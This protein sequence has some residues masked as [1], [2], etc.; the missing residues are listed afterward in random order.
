M[1]V[2]L[3]LLPSILFLAQH[4]AGLDHQCSTSTCGIQGPPV[5]FPFRIKG[6]Q[7]PHC[8]YPEVGFDLRCSEKNHTVMELPNSWKLLVQTIDYKSQ[9]IYASDFDG[10]CLPKRLLLS[11]NLSDIYP[12][13]LM[14]YIFSFTLFNCSSKK[15]HSLQPITCLSSLH[16]YVYAI[17]SQSSIQDLVLLLSCSKLQNIS[18]ASEYSLYSQENVLQFSWYYPEC[19]YCEEKGKYCRL[20]GSE[21]EC[22]GII[23]PAKGTL[24][25]V[26]LSLN[27]HPTFGSM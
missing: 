6:R 10:V 14:D 20:K 1:V 21:T 5:R 16:H 7:Q 11:S 13:R 3:F 2:C 22:Y 27:T 18:V 24:F 23:K 15:G 26:H 25:S 9:V 12:F 8:S 19:S 17:T 4:G